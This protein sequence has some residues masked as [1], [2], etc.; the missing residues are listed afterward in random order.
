MKIRMATLILKSFQC[1]E[2]KMVE[3]ISHV[4]LSPLENKV[5]LWEIRAHPFRGVNGISEAGAP[6]W[7]Y[8]TPHVFSHYC[9]GPQLHEA[10]GKARLRSTRQDSWGHLMRG[11]APRSPGN[12]NLPQ[13]WV[14][15]QSH[16]NRSWLAQRKV[17][18]HSFQQIFIVHLP[19][20]R[21]WGQS[22]EQKRHGL[23]PLCT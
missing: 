22:S 10:Q 5:A 9:C 6:F 23:H 14:S 20:A 18:Y 13:N 21:H 2:K 4:I 16:L 8:W 15:W 12:Q 1:K 11:W 17:T 3:T 19:W 7:R